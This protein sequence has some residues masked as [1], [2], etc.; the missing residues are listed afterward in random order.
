MKYILVSADTTRRLV[1]LVNEML[2]EGY[3]C[4]GG[5]AVSI[6]HGDGYYNEVYSQAMIKVQQ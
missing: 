2:E 3:T 6:S 5:I 4:Q 1:E